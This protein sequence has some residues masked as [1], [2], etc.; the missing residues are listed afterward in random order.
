MGKERER[1][2][3]REKESENER[4]EKMRQQ[5]VRGT[6]SWERMRD[7]KKNKKDN[8]IENIIQ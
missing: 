1:K 2:R 5:S 7:S 3:G 4:N 8:E 6:R